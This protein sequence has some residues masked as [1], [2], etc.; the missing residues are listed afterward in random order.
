MLFF[1]SLCIYIGTIGPNRGT[2]NTLMRRNNQAVLIDPS[3][4]PE[5]ADAITRF[6]AHGGSITLFSPFGKDPL[7][8]H[9]ELC[10]E[11]EQN[12]LLQYPEF[13]PFFHTV[14]N[15]EFSLFREGL[16]FFI[17]LSQ[18]LEHSISV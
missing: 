14:V 16:L 1:P 11:R 5:P 13:G 6:S 15:G 9:E 18:Q 10:E 12:F 3:L 2:P 7:E 4:L 8:D 17:D